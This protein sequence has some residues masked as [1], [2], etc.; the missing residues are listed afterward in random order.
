MGKLP[1][2]ILDF[3]ARGASL[4]FFKKGIWVK[5]SDAIFH[6]ISLNPQLL[7]R[8][9]DLIFQTLVRL[10]VILWQHTEGEPSDTPDYFNR[11]FTEKMAAIGLPCEKAYG[12][13]LKHTI[14]PDGL[15][16]T[17]KPQALQEFFPLKNFAEWRPTKKTRI[18]FTCPICGAVAMAAGG[19]TLTCN[20]E[21]CNAEMVKEQLEEM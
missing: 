17:F 14:A 5:G 16:A 10:M 15:Y 20:T 1:A 4:G 13:N 9:D 12:K 3:N 2:C 8:E 6:Q 18:K 7:K 11:N 19:V 21:K